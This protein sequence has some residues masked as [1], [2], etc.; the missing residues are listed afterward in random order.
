MGRMSSRG[1]Q[2]HRLLTHLSSLLS[3]Q[4]HSC[5]QKAPAGRTLWVSIDPSAC[6]VCHSSAVLPY[7]AQ[8]HPARPQMQAISHTLCTGDT[9]GSTRELCVTRGRC[10][11]AEPDFMALARKHPDLARHVRPNRQGRGV[12]DF[13]SFEAARCVM[14]MHALHCSP[15]SFT[16]CP[17]SH[18]AS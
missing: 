2:M 4:A 3:M 15:P 5:E 6:F 1:L 13:T 9:M 10:A 7:P 16:A 18:D 8:P 11:H 17:L 14:R 12:I